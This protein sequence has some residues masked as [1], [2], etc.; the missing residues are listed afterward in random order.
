[1]E[2]ASLVHTVEKIRFVEFVY[3][4]RAEWKEYRNIPFLTWPTGSPC[5]QGNLYLLNLIK[6]KYSTTGRGGSLRQYAY[7]ISRYITFCFG[8]SIGLQDLS[9][10][11]FRLFLKS[12]KVRRNSENPVQ[13]NTAIA[14][15]RVVMDFLAYLDELHNTNIL[16]TRLEA[17]RRAQTVKH[18]GKTFKTETWWHPSLGTPSPRRRRSAIEEATIAALVDAAD[19]SSEDDY[20]V[21]RRKILVKVLETLGARIGE[22]AQIR[23]EDINEAHKNGAIKISSL[24]RGGPHTREIPILA[25][26]LVELEQFLIERK[27]ALKRAKQKDTGYLFTSSRTGRPLSATSL[28]NEILLLRRI[29]GISEKASAHLF[30]HRFITKLLIL[31]IEAHELRSANDLRKAMHEVEGLKLVLMEWTGH[32]SMASLNG[33]IDL[34]YSEW[35]SLDKTVDRALKNRA[36]DTFIRSVSEIAAKVGVSMTTEEFHDSVKELQAAYER[37]A[38]AIFKQTPAP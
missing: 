4:G 13:K 25:Q 2:G 6:R 37:D 3:K 20:V 8:N 21:S 16:T 19:T 15:G 31:L 32:K 7:I 12:L 30:R 24:K 34:A 1:M 29:A 17:E 26:D 22:V 10:A 33:Y 36:R 28:G 5:N 35:K 11:H 27:I 9:A 38:R 14:S 18:N 23:V